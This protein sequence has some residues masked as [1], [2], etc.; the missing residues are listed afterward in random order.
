MSGDD[1]N[2]PTVSVWCVCV[3]VCACVVVDIGGG[4]SGREEGKFMN[5]SNIAI[6]IMNG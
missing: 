1:G 4:V 3:C 6:R 5:G 2:V